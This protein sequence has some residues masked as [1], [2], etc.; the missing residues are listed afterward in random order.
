MRVDSLPIPLAFRNAMPFRWHRRLLREFEFQ[1]STAPDRQT[2]EVL[3][4]TERRP[5]RFDIMAVGPVPRHEND[6]SLVLIL[7]R[8]EETA[9]VWSGDLEQEGEHLLSEAG[10]VPA[11]AGVWKA[12]HHGSDT[13]GSQGFLDRLDPALILVSCGAD[14]RYGHPS[15]GPYVVAGDTIGVLR[16][17]LA[18][19]ISLSW[20]PNGPPRVT[21]AATGL[22]PRDVLSSMRGHHSHRT[23]SPSGRLFPEASHG[24]AAQYP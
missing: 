4:F 7:R 20:G 9:M 2:L 19:T 8:G 1:T 14:N 15:H 18:G 11:R 6:A 10:L 23:P 16:T 17:D 21:W 22:T 5:V 12:G 13:S 3:F 24:S